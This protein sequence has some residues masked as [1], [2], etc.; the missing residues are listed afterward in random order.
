MKLIQGQLRKVDFVGEKTGGGR[1]KETQRKKL[2]AKNLVDSI[3]SWSPLDR[4][5][6]KGDKRNGKI[7]RRPKPVA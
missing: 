5:M 1:E 7:M 3:S 2:R 4:G 6:A